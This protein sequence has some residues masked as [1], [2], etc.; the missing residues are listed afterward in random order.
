MRPRIYLGFLVACVLAL[1]AAGAGTTRYPDRPMTL[2]LASSAGGSLDYISRLVSEK[3][4]ARLGKP[5]VLDFRPGAG[6]MIGALAMAKARPD[7]YTIGSLTTAIVAAQGFGRESAF[8]V[9][10]F[11]PLGQF[12]D[13]RVGLAINPKLPFRTVAELVAYAKAHPG[14]LNY[15]T[16]GVGSTPHIAAAQ[17]MAATQ[18]QMVAVPYQSDSIATQDLVAGG[19]I[20]LYFSVSATQ[21]PLYKEGR[22]RILAF[23]SATRSAAAP[24][25]PTFD[26]LGLSA[27]AFHSWGGW[28]FPPKTPPDMAN[29]VSGAL[30]GLSSDREMRKRFEA[31]GCELVDLGPERFDELIKSDI[32]KFHDL[33][34]SIGLKFD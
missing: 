6:N 24:E 21:I 27:A 10:E 16:T 28:I 30:A 1:P 3:V 18:T 23:T 11:V 31:V 26:E 33:V 25:V 15:G 13:Y 19:R 17:F 12:V 34:K 20:D 4:S 8:D 29:K 22:I 5:V 2:I 7:G 32:G 14:K 9:R